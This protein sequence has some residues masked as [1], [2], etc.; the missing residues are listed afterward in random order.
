[1][2]TTGTGLSAVKPES[3][4]SAALNWTLTILMNIVLPTVTYVLLSGPAGMKD[5]PA[6]L[7]S[8]LW[9]VLEIGYTVSRQRHIDE[10]SVFVLLGIVIGVLTTLF[11]DSARAVFLKD[12]ITT[13]TIG[14][15]MLVTLAFGRPLTFYLARRFA[16]DGSKV[17]RDWWDGLWRHPRFRLVQRR[18]GAVWGICLL[19]EALIRA[20][21]T[22]R[23]GTSAMVLV[24]NVVPYAVIAALIYYSVST[25]RREQATAQRQHGEQ[26]APPTAPA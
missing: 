18:L 4:Q 2:T 16:T 12:S 10:F 9:P 26:A 25:G 17:Q 7:L 20:L 3:G 14:V 6:L 5:I 23:L 11:S 22:W 24:N 15:V 8:G 13:G 21:L 1:M 19:G